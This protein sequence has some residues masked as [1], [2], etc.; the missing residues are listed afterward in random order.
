ME[1]KLAS[2]SIGQVEADALIL[3][4]YEGAP[5]AGVTDSRVQDL[6]ESG[7]FTGKALE[8]AILHGP[9]GL[10]AKRLLLAGGG[11][12]GKFTSA[13]ARNLSGA[14]LRHLK[15]KGIHSIAIVAP[16]S[17]DATSSAL[18]EGALLGNHETDRYK[19]DP[20]K[21]EKH[22]NS[23]TVLG[24]SQAGVD[25]GRILGEAQNVSRMLS[26]E[27]GNLLPPTKLA[28]HARQ[29]AEASGLECEIL[30][31]AQMEKLG[32]GCVLGVAMGS[33]EPPAFIIMKYCPKHTSTS[34]HLGLVGKGV[35]FDTGGISIKPADSM[36]KMKY[37]MCGGA[38]VI[39]AMQAIAKL[40]PSVRVTA[41][42]PTVENMPGSRAL[43][44]GDILTSLSGKTVDVLNTDAEG[45]LILI[46]ALTYAQQQGCTHL[47]DA[48]TLTGAIGVALGTIRAGAFTNN[49]AF[50]DKFMAAA[51]AEGERM[52]QLPMDDEYL[53]VM[54]S[55]VADLQ[56]IGNRAGGSITAAKFLQEF[57]GET[58]WVHLDIASTAWL[59][60]AK[61]HMVK[62]PTGICVRS[63]VQL[64]MGW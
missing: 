24:G 7:E 34:D 57:V 47:V 36:D 26:D 51:K 33:A 45:R 55:P 40:K 52:W 28:A 23:F 19:T 60:E 8:L 42:I 14:A 11:K 1:I 12:T 21:N 59:D 27:P 49:Q 18:V 44:P 31:Q 20:K 2:T 58:P 35:T 16:D 62:G 15:S 5:P 22:I 56:N 32:M 50:L 38:A 4:G 30:D 37:D 41:F 43:R 17:S 3:I 53:E 39:G 54:K 48:A 25:R 29:V 13:D 9:A 63:F 64:A 61:P 10:K 46:D 6:Y